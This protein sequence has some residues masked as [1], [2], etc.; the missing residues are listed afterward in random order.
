MIVL[1]STEQ[2]FCKKTLTLGLSDVFL[3]ILLR[4][5]LSFS[6]YRRVRRPSDHIILG[7][8]DVNL[9]LA[10][11]TLNQLVKVIYARVIHYEVA[12]FHSPSLEGSHQLHVV[13]QRKQIKLPLANVK[14]S[15]Y[16]IWNSGRR[17]D[18]SSP[19]SYLFHHLLLSL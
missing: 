13:L 4:F 5:L 14:V 2:V 15:I 9:I 1:K 12:V 17:L 3:M 19:F 11:V 7:V 10:M 8:C 18:S 16:S 6:K